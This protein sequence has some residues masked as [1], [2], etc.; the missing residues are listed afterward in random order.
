MKGG[1]SMRST[2]VGYVNRNKQ[3]NMGRAEKQAV[4]PYANIY[5]MYCGICG[6]EYFAN[7]SDVHLKKCPQCQGGKD[8][9][10]G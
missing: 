2:D 1:C 9:A 8:T 5:K 3:K 6:Y 10:V 4:R 7:G